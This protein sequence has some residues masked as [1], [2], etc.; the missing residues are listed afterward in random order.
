MLASRQ[1]PHAIVPVR[2]RFLDR[3]TRQFSPAEYKKA[4]GEFTQ[5]S[6][7]DY[8]EFQRDELVAE[9]MRDLIMSR[10]RV[11]EGEAFDAFAQ[12]ETTAKVK[13]VKFAPNYY[14]SR[15]VDRSQK[16]IDTWAEKNVVDIEK[17]LEARKPH[18][19][20][21]CRQV[22]QNPGARREDRDRRREEGPRATRSR[23]RRRGSRAARPS[24]TWRARSAITW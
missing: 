18:L 22:S 9:R 24:P 19:A 3:K 11:S 21:G 20:D 16:A 8:R 1:I 14:V 6:E 15:S 5:L 12:K 10:V 4:I 13:Y 23:R 2:E 17:D 7:E